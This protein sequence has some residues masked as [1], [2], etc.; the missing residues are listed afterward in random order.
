MKENVDKMVFSPLFETLD[1]ICD[2]DI[3]DKIL[4]CNRTLAFSRV[5]DV[6]YYMML[7]DTIIIFTYSYPVPERGLK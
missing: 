1:V 3:R 5:G 6:H 7:G 2:A 4:Y